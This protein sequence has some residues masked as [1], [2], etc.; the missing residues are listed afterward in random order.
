MQGF[1]KKLLMINLINSEGRQDFIELF[2]ELKYA[3]I[4]NDKELIK[5]LESQDKYLI[6]G[7][8]DFF[9]DPWFTVNISNFITIFDDFLNS[10]KD[11]QSYNR[12]LDD[13]VSL[14][15]EITRLHSEWMDLGF[16]GFI[17]DQIN[18]KNYPISIVIKKNSF[19]LSK[20]LIEL[21]SMID[22]DQLT[23]SKIDQ[24]P[25]IKKDLF[26]KISCLNNELKNLM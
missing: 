7:E 21:Y 16:P 18:F 22:R 19:G 4:K 20:A 26:D 2:E 12:F 6:F 5:L 10:N 13:L 9:E 24:N 17:S 25:L 8:S 14:C 3:E 23:Y 15:I 11:K 1:N